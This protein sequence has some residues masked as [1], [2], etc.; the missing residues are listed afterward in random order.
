MDD[1]TAM[2]I[3][4]VASLLLFCWVVWLDSRDR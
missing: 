2:V 3:I 1:N 4:G